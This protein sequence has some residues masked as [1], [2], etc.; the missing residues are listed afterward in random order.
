MAKCIRA[1]IPR[2]PQH[3]VIVVPEGAECIRATI[4]RKPQHAYKNSLNSV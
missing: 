3:A 4:P 1:T 2:K